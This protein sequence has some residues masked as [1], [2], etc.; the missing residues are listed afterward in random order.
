MHSPAGL[1]VSSRLGNESPGST[2]QAPNSAP[3]EATSLTLEAKRE[4]ARQKRKQQSELLEAS[5]DGDYMEVEILLGEGAEVDWVGP[6]GKTALHLAA[7]YG[8][9]R[10][11]KLLLDHGADIEAHCEPYGTPMMILHRAGSTPLHWAAAGDDTGGRQES[12]VRLLLERGANVNARSD[13]FRTPLQQ[14][15]MHTRTGNDVTATIQLLLDNGAI[16]NAFDTEGWAPLHEAAHYGKFD[17]AEILLNHGADIEGRPPMS[18]PAYATNPVLLPGHHV[19]TPLLLARS[20]WSEHLI[21]VLNKHGANLDAQM[22]NGDTLLHMAAL[23]G[24]RTIV[25]LL[26]QLGANPDIREFDYGSTALHKAA[27]AGHREAI[28]ALL[29]YGADTLIVNNL[30]QTAVEVARQCGNAELVDN[31]D[32][33]NRPPRP[34]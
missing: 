21:R 32:R 17:I 3:S 8:H 14:A 7:Q 13:R 27:F 10:L 26:L 5:K 22:Q 16:A 25:P 15:V 12:V 29:R 4:L 2:S 33:P 31:W 19:R 20:E 18:D 24:R 23:E 1:Q 9:K 11:V 6:E 30:G 34:G 28:Q